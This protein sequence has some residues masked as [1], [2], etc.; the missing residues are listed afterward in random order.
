MR[1]P[2]GD[3]VLLLSSNQTYL[4][5]IYGVDAPEEGQA[6]YAEAAHALHERA[7]GKHAIAGVSARSLWPNRGTPVNRGT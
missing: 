3:T 2:D 1:V 4:V 5:R 7:Y 6:M